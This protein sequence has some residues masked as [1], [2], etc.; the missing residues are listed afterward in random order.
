[1]AISTSASGVYISTELFPRL[2]LADVMRGKTVG[3]GR[4][5]SLVARGEV[6]TAMQPISELP[7]V[8]G[9]N[10]V[11]P[12]PVEVQKATVYATG[13]AASAKEP[14]AARALVRFLTSPAA[15]PAIRKSALS[16]PW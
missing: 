15:A 14:E 3:V 11:G 2:G 10:C 13:I 9:M 6:E 16:S 7:P 1:M 12:L 5:G 4:G 8:A